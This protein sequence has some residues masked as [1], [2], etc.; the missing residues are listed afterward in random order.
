MQRW[1]FLIVTTTLVMGLL[2]CHSSFAQSVA[3][4]GVGNQDS[5]CLGRVNAAPQAAPTCSTAD[6][7]TTVASAQWIGSQYSAPQCSYQAPP[8]CPAGYTE[9]S[10][11]AWTGAA[12]TAPGCAAPSP[13]VSQSTEEAACVTAW[14]ASSADMLFLVPRS[15]VSGP[16]NGNGMDQYNNLI[17]VEETIGF[18]YSGNGIIQ[19]TAPSTSTSNDLFYI[20]YEFG[21]PW[22]F[23]WV[24]SGT[25]N[26]IALGSAGWCSP[27]GGTV[28]CGGG[29][30]GN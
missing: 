16:L 14:E 25:N 19:G 30:V 7:W 8:A 2:A 29:G 11:P 22:F 1:K 4:C 3:G 28:N 6:G 27:N 21:A 13:P 18:I 5:T 12:W 23:C 24:A 10:A 9:T 26:V 15:T 17:Q 20:N